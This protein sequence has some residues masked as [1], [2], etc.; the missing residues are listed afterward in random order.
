LSVLAVGLSQAQG[1]GPSPQAAQVA[2]GTAFTYQGQID[3]NSSPFDGNCDLQFALYDAASGGAQIGTLQTTGNVTVTNGLF[4]VPLDFGSGAFN[5]DARWLEI[6]ARCPA[7]SG[8]Y[9][10]LAPRQALTPAPYALAL[11]GLYTQQNATSPNIIGGHIS[12]TVTVG[13]VGA[14]IGGGGANGSPNTVSGNYGTVSGGIRNTASSDYAT[15]GGGVE[16]TASG[17]SVIGGG[18]HNSANSNWGAIGGGVN[19]T[20]NNDS[21]TIGGGWGNN[22]S[23]STATI[24]GGSGNS[25][26]GHWATVG[27]GTGND[28]NGFAAV[29]SGGYYNSAGDHGFVGGGENNFASYYGYS[30]VSG[31]YYNN[32]V[33][34]YATIGGGDHNSIMW[35]DGSPSPY[36]TIG[37]GRDNT[38]GVGTSYATIPG[39]YGAYATRTGQMA[40][41]SGSF[42]NAGDAQSSLYIMRNVTTDTTPTELYLNGVNSLLVSPYNSTMTFDIFVVARSNTA[43]SAGYQIRGVIENNAGAASFIGTPIVTILGEDVPAWDV[44]VFTTRPA[45]VDCLFIRVTGAAGATI[46]WVATVRTVEVKW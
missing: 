16:N 20:I 19:N 38:I 9:T 5:G 1:P 28:A 29:V 6:S 17:T 26:S 37:G 33:S 32:A 24:A 41:A 30:T 21:V 36:A 23:G 46:R 13:V 3:V 10:A 45:T 14:T 44:N 7:G 2:L 11:P 43:A 22:A 15:V 12:N 27:G 35:G 40:Y 39:G 31:G 25:S 34:D 8:N 4:T 18:W 42:A